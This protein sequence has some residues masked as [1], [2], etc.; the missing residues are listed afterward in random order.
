MELD[1]L[2]KHKLNLTHKLN[3]I[4][5][6]TG[7]HSLLIM[8]STSTHMVVFAAN[9]QPIYSAGDAGGKSTQPGCKELYCERVVDTKL[10]LLVSDAAADIEW[11]DNEDLVE[12]GLG[13]YYGVPI[14]DGD[15]AVG[16]VCALNQTEFNFE[17]GQPSAKQQIIALKQEVESLLQQVE[18][19]SA[20]V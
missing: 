14:M 6:A 5:Q 18:C 2:Q 9:E 13:V 1:N 16:T 8:Q 10:E 4:A 11:Q 7:L 17:K 3:D 19:S 15:N 12:F 20:V